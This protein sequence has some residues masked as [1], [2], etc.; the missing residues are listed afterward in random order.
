[1]TGIETRLK[2]ISGL[3]TTA[4]RPDAIIPPHAYV[5]LPEIDYHRAFAHGRLDINPTVTVLTQRAL[6]ST[7]QPEL[8]SYMDTSGAHSIHAAIETDKTLG[9]SANGVDCAVQNARETDLELGNIKW[10]G[11][12]FTLRVTATGGV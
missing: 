6:D 10:Y 7:G 5:S 9:L 12:V 2:T 11:A 8:A 3:H 4:Y 1:M